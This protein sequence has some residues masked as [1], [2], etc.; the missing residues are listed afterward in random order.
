LI[1]IKLPSASS[2]SSGA[3]GGAIGGFG[4]G[5]VKA[6]RAQGIAKVDDLLTRALA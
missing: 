4:T 6:M 2:R 3:I 1:A 5:M